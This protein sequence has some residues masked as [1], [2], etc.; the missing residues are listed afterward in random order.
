MLKGLSLNNCEFMFSYLNK[1][2]SK[3]IVA[4]FAVFIFVFLLNFQIASAKSYSYDLIDVKININQ[5]STFDVSEEQI[6]NYI[7][8]YHDAWRSISLSKIDQIS[9]IEVIDG[10]TGQLMAYSAKRLDKLDP[11]SWGRFTFYK[12]NGAQNIIW[13]YNLSDTTHKWIVKYKVH[14]GI[15][16]FSG[17]D[18]LVWYIFDQY[19]GLIK[20]ANATVT[21]PQEVS[22]SNVSLNAYRTDIHQQYFIDKNPLPDKKSFIFEAKNFKAQEYFKIQ[23]S[24]P[25]GI[26][27]QS[28]YWQDFLRIYIFYILAGLITLANFIFIIIHWY[29]REVRPVGRGTIIP[30]YAPPQNLRPAMAEVLLKEKV[31]DKGWSATVIDLAVRGFIKIKEDTADWEEALVRATVF[32]V[33]I[34]VLVLAVDNKFFGLI[35][36]GFPFIGAFIIFAHKQIKEFIS[37][38]MVGKIK[39][40]FVPKNYILEKVENTDETVLEEYERKFLKVIFRNGKTFSIKAMK[41]ISNERKR[42]LYETMERLKENLYSETTIDTKAFE[43]GVEKE[44]KGILV[45]FSSLFITFFVLLLISALLNLNPVINEQFIF[46]FVIISNI[47]LSYAYLKYEAY[48]SQKGLILKEDW[49]GFKMYLETAERYRMQNLTPQTFEKYLPYAIIFGI[50][51]KWGKAFESFNIQNPSWYTGAYV[52]S[53]FHSGGFSSGSGFSPAGFSASF[54]S[55][56]SSAFSSAVGAGSAGGGGGGGAGG[57]GGGGGGGAS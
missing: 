16:F 12:E 18:E 47:L 24:W 48:L 39:E 13:Y 26:V 44:K 54:S 11:A 51:K 22:V 55:S 41:H 50:E 8:E 9:N 36:I 2:F 23:I 6:F 43:S 3:K 32:A 38:L 19:G 52:G 28:A 7:G 20:E 10:E 53:G 30:Q 34:G 21:L 45:F 40:A 5:D 56:F 31:T 37:L 27:S 1:S 33:L 42:E 15:G 35:I 29:W 49:L 46:I 14:G 4:F 25:K 17:S 57:G